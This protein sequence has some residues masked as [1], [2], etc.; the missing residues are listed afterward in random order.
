MSLK[1][2]E[3][4]LLSVEGAAERVV[5]V[6]EELRLVALRERAGLTRAQLDARIMVSQPCVAP[7]ADDLE[8]MSSGLTRE[9]IAQ[10]NLPPRQRRKRDARGKVEATPAST[11]PA[12]YMPYGERKPIV[13]A[14]SLSQLNGPINGTVALPNHLDWSGHRVYDLD[15]PKRLVT[16]YKTVLQ[17]AQTVADLA[18]WLNADRLATEWASMYLPPK[19]RRLW[20]ARFPQLGDASAGQR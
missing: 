20:E 10:E 12:D 11:P 1:D 3:A 18:T 17:E 16:M 19:I 15:D 8:N 2:W 14:D 7:V 9:S 13:V 5:E 4:R 6:E